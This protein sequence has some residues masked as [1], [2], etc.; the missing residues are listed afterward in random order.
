[1]KVNVNSLLRIISPSSEA[2][3]Y[4]YNFRFAMVNTHSKMAGIL[5]VKTRRTKIKKKQW[6]TE[7]EPRSSR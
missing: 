4:F 2:S 3:Y 5:V 1:M 6:T 7:A